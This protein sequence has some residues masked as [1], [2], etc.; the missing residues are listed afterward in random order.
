MI[1]NI[2]PFGPLGNPGRSARPSA[3]Q[4]IALRTGAGSLERRRLRS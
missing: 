1:L 2:K 4:K 3:F